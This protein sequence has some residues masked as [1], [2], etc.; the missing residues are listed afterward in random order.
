MVRVSGP[1]QPQITQPQDNTSVY[2]EVEIV[3]SDL[4]GERDIVSNIHGAGSPETHRM[5]ILRNAD[6]ESKKKLAKNLAG[7]YQTVDLTGAF[8]NIADFSVPEPLLQ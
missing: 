8:I 7:D 3:E 2:G 4:S 6:I 1:P 5:T